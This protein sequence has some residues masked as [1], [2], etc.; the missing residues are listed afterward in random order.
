MSGMNTCSSLPRGK[1][2]R[3]SRRRATNCTLA[4]ACKAPS[5]SACRLM[6]WTSWLRP[7]HAAH[8]YQL[9]EQVAGLPQDPAILV[10]ADG[11]GVRHLRL[12]VARVDHRS[13]ES[14]VGK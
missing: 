8:Y 14:R 4:M 11:D 10:I 1:F 12:T 7:P 2:R 5:R 13:E 9:R 3:S 6:A